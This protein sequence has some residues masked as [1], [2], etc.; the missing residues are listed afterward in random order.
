MVSRCMSVLLAIAAAALMVTALWLWQFAPAAA[1][2]RPMA[3]RSAFE[4]TGRCAAVAIAAL[5]QCII[6]G[7]VIGLVFRPTQLDRW[8]CRL[9]ALAS[10]VAGIAAIAIGMAGR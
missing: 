7:G 1:M 4:M 6:V 8:F 5:A 10:T 2:Q 3:A 9:A